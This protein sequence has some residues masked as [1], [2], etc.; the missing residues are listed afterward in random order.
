M[1][2]QLLNLYSVAC[3]DWRNNQWARLMV[4]GPNTEVVLA[5]VKEHMEGFRIT[6]PYFICTTPDHVWKEI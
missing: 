6:A 4:S 3:Y 5:E 2:V 1:S